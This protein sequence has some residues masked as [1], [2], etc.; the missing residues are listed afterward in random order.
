L[1]VLDSQ[2]DAESPAERLVDI[3]AK[4]RTTLTKTDIVA[5]M[6]LYGEELQ[7]Q[8]AEGRTVKTPAG[9]FYLC[10]SGSLVSL[11][12]SFTPGLQ[13]RNHAL[14]IHY[15][16]DR[17]FEAAVR[18]G[19]RLV[20][21]EL[22][23]IA[24]PQPRSFQSASSGSF[25]ATKPGDILQIRGFRLKFDPKNLEEGVFFLSSSGTEARSSLYPQIL[26]KTIFAGAPAGLAAGS[27]ALAIRSLL[28]GK[29]LREGR[30]EGLIVAET[31]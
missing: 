29:E 8:L 5:A 13:D 7:K 26:P 12:E 6:Q 30:L 22:L 27:Y 21:G 11:D 24:A 23:D 9:S 19:V 16:P 18:G 4:G 10:A 20:R 1:Y 25:D 14:R 28:G 17:E 2:Y 3:M 15:R 31:Y